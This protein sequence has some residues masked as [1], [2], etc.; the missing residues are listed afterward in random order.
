MVKYIKQP[1]DD[2]FAALSDATRRRII[3]RLAQGDATAGEIAKL[4]DISAPAVS[5]HLK[6]LERAGL[7]ERRREGRTHRFSL[8]AGPM[9]EAVVWI[10]TYQAFWER[11]LDQL[12]ELFATTPK[13]EE[14]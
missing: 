3:D 14:E 8:K 1:L 6:V 11:Q 12:E 4:F 2:V 7:L 5:K 13:S 9:R 10:E